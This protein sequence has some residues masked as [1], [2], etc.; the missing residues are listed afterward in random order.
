[1]HMV[2]TGIRW[3]SR[4]ALP[5]SHHPPVRSAAITVRRPPNGWVLL[6][7]LLFV[8]VVVVVV[9]VSSRAFFLAVEDRGHKHDAHKAAAMMRQMLQWRKDNNV[10]AIRE[11]I[12]Q[13]QKFHP[14]SVQQQGVGYPYVLGWGALQTSTRVYLQQ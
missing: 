7:L 10:D 12:M 11:D 3:C 2:Y 14:R 5:S 1:M 6:L 8:V 9:V 4:H 13:N